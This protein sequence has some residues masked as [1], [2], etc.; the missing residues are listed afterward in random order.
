MLVSVCL[1]TNDLEKA[2]QFYVST[3]F[4]YS[5]SEG[6]GFQDGY[7]SV[8]SRRNNRKAPRSFLS[9]LARPKRNDEANFR[10]SLLIQCVKIDPSPSPL[11]NV[12]RSQMRGSF[13]RRIPDR[14][15]L[16]AFMP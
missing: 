14:T 4:N 10:G 11:E 2:S 13:H 7:F 8:F 16:V 15:L 9:L 12:K 5:K 6:S 1:G 3:V